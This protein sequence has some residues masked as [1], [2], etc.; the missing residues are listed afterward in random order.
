MTASKKLIQASAGVGGTEP[1]Y[2]YEI[3]NSLRFNTGNTDY[4]TFTP[5]TNGNNTTFTLRFMVK[6]GN[7]NKQ[8]WLFLTNVSVGNAYTG[9][10]FN[11]NN[12][13]EYFSAT[14][15]ID[16]QMITS[17]V[18][19]DVSS[20]YDIV[21]SVSSTNVDIYVNGVEQPYGTVNQPSGADTGVNLAG[22]LMS[23]STST[24]SNGTIDGYVAEMVLVDGQALTP[25]SFGEFKNGIWVPKDCS[26]LSFGTNGAYLKFGNSGA[27][28]TDSSGNGNNFTTSG[29]TA[30]DQMPDTPTNNF[31]TLNP[32]T[33]IDSGVSSNTL[34]DGNLKSVAT[35]NSNYRVSTIGLSS[36]KWY[37]EGISSGP[38]SNTDGIGFG[39][40]V[41]N[42][43]LYRTN[44]N[45]LVD[46]V[47]SP[48]GGATWSSNN[49]I[50]SMT[51]DAD[52]GQVTAYVNGVSQGVIDTLDMSKPV[53]A[54]AFNRFAGTISVNFGQDSSFGGI[55]TRQNNTDA[56]GL[57]DFYYTP[58]TDHLAL[59]TANLPEP[60]IGPNSDIKPDDVF[61][62]E[63]STGNG[64]SKASGG[65]MIFTDV[66]FTDG[67]YTVWGKNRDA[68]DSWGCF[69][70]LRGSN[71][72][73][74]LD[75]NLANTTN[76]ETLEFTSAGCKLG[77]SHL[78]NASG[79]DYVFYMFKV[80]PGFFDM[81][82]FTSTGSV[83]NVSHDL[84]V[85][86]KLVIGNNYS[87]LYKNW[88]VQVDGGQ[89]T[90]P[91]TD[92]LLLDLS[93]AA[94]DDATVWNDTA[95]T[96]SV[97]TLGTNANLNSATPY[98][99]ILYMF[100]DV[101]GFCKT[102]YY[103][104]NGSADGAFAYQGFLPDF[105]I[106][107]RSDLAQVW[108]VYDSARNPSNVIS[109][110]LVPDLPDAEV[111]GISA[112]DFVSNGVKMRDTNAAR[113]GV[114]SHITLSIGTPSKYS[115]AR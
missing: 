108:S 79:E 5:S 17:S 11:A 97:V 23:T 102:G 48:T 103:A 28:G 94:A 67:D 14:P 55:K 77:N 96:D 68:A 27:L 78:V 61:R 114:G 46:G 12:T 69:D 51:L 89:V 42:I 32:L 80:T 52:T 49:E 19:R 86:P 45:K 20:W 13:L 72:Y 59:C 3:E 75:G 92:Y 111:G 2:D 93:Y 95:P 7:L 47:N 90:D 38:T 58:P 16:A 107:K 70:T 62:V 6:L 82:Q 104:G 109:K 115:N 40:S 10:R 50:C 105:F 8:R 43:A 110:V 44:G 29:L 76:T 26:G 91:E 21:I 98:E 100:A 83:L 35:A 25:T 65:K 9:V 53:F 85:A 112:M 99:G 106:T 74:I 30:S 39:N 37:F 33:E 56:N 31:S 88:I 101:E 54:V 18:F 24:P 41:S 57:G 1:F 113:N 87:G 81:Q 36:K 34:S 66:D 63:L 60:T 73:I 15:G 64:L 84:G 22:N 71:K 4:L